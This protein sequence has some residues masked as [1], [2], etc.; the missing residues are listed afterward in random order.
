M[1]MVGNLGAALSAV[2]F[3]FFVANVTLP[4]FA[5]QTGTASSFFVFAAAMNLLAV[6]AWV[7]MNPLRRARQ[8]SRGALQLRL[9][10]FLVIVMLVVLALIY[11]KFWM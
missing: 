1:N 7:F 4:F 8:I 9:C 3:P 11:T 2:V 5:P 10:F 6:I